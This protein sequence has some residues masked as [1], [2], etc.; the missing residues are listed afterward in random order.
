M[1]LAD[2]KHRYVELTVCKLH[3]A[4]C[5]VSDDELTIAHFK[6][7]C[8]QISTDCTRLT[9]FFGKFIAVSVDFRT[10]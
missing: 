2:R 1:K 3:I 9:F 5:N 4:A 10:S 7:A 8:S 6:K